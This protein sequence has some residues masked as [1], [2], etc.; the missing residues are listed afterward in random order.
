[1][2]AAAARPWPPTCPDCPPPCR[3]RRTQLP[4][5]DVIIFT[6]FSPKNGDKIGVFD[7]KQS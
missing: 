2:A 5:T 4:G 3:L 1:M 7:S 6:I